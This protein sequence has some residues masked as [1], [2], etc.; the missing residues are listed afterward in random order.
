MKNKQRIYKVVKIKKVKGYL[1]PFTRLPAEH[2]TRLFSV[3]FATGI[4]T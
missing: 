1:L 4:T 2:I 3:A